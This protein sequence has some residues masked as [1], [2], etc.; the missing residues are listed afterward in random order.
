MPELEIKGGMRVFI[1]DYKEMRQ[2][3][4]EELDARERRAAR[5]WKHMALPET[6]RGNVVSSAITL[7]NS[8]GQV[9]GP[10]S[11]YVWVIRA[12]IVTGLASGATPDIVNFYL[13]DR[14]GG[15]IWWQLNGNQF[16]ETFSNLQRVIKPGETLS[17]QNSGS[18]AATGLIIVSGELDE[19]PAEMLFK[20]E[21]GG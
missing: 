15:P 21:G 8:K 9:C 20:A 2:A 5:G 13:N 16:G 11:G 12:L 17:L 1:P 3:T 14:F 6:L 4:G 7:G 18:L 10:E 19:M